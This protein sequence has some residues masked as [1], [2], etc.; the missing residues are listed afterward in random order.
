MEGSSGAREQK[1]STASL[2][3]A[4]NSILKKQFSNSKHGKKTKVVFSVKHNQLLYLYK[5]FVG[6][7]LT[8]S[9][10]QISVEKKK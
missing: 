3:D 1:L 6:K 2:P 8:L 5:I 7:W 9:L 4:Q 10:D